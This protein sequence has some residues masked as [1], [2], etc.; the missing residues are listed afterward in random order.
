MGDIDV[1]FSTKYPLETMEYALS[2]KEIKNIVSQ[3]EAVSHVQLKNGREMDVK[4]VKPE[5]WGSLL[6][7]YTG[8]KLHNINL[9]TYALSKGL[10]LSEYGIKN[11]KGKVFEFPEEV[12]FY[13]KLG[14]QY[15][16]PELREGEEELE[17]A[18]NNQIPYL[19]QLSDIR[20]DLH[21][22]SDFEFACSHD[23]GRSPLSHILDFAIENRY[24]YIGIS[25]HNPRTSDLS[26]SARKKIINDRKK[27]LQ[28]EHFQYE[29]SV[30]TKIPKMLIGME[31]DIRPDG[32]LA[33]EDELMDLFDYTI[34]SI[35]S[36]FEQDKDNNTKRII[37]ALSHPKATILGH[38]T[39]RLLNIRNGISADWAEIIDFA[40][41]NNKIM[42]IN[43]SP[44]RQDLPD[45]LV[46][47]AIGAKV[48][49]IINTDSHE[50]DQ[51]S[52]MRYGV[53]VARR[54]WCQKAD[55]INTFSWSDLH[56]VLNLNS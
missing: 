38:P 30:K 28:E 6:Q 33:L 14:L 10:S 22:H 50:A 20:G 52:G 5:Q 54:G 16:P 23:F 43:S 45:D 49:I 53:W 39:G 25:D 26:L 37:K 46:K 32:E 4:C 13:E 44:N 34:V 3:G 2:Y 47:Q 9:R 56:R 48:K 24:E 11:S 27:Y 36:S 51:L 29:N 19:I 15:I 31:V 12:G 41:K 7:H 21:I 17:K 35:H 18:K 40:A 8:S 42:E 55:V 1:A